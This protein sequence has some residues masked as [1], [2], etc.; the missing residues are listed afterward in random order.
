[1]RE[2]NELK[3]RIRKMNQELREKGREMTDWKTKRKEVERKDARQ[4]ERM[5]QKLESLMKDLEERTKRSLSED[6]Q[7]SQIWECK[8]TSCFWGVDTRFDR[9]REL[10]DE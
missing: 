2:T 3:E 4:D 6:T 7:A 8:V 5:K 1:M 10:E 9:Q